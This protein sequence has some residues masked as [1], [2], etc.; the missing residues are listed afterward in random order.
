MRREAVPFVALCCHFPA[1]QIA[2]DQP[3]RLR[4]AHAGQFPD[5]PMQQAALFTPLL[6]IAVGLQ[7]PADPAIYLLLP[8]CLK[9]HLFPR[10]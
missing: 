10:R 8:L 3:R 2:S 7:E 5:I 6:P 1:S 9:L 4:S